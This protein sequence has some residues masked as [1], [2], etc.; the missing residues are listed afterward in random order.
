M[1]NLER[2]Q[3]GIFNIGSSINIEELNE[4][5]LLE[6]LITIENALQRY[7]KIFIRNIYEKEILNGVCLRD[8]SLLNSVEENK[9]YRIYLENN[10]NFIGLGMKN[11]KG[12][13]MIKLLS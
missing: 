3:T 12:F 1:W 13:K 9:I 10:N 5:N 8:I 6:N 11:N 7:D 2:I 4:E